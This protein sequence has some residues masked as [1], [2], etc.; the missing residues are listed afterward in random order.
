MGVFACAVWLVLACVPMQ[1]WGWRPGGAGAE[2]ARRP[3]RQVAPSDLR[4]ERP[5]DRRRSAPVES[6]VALPDEPSAAPSPSLAGPLD[7]G[8]LSRAAGRVAQTPP[9]AQGTMDHDV[10]AVTAMPWPPATPPDVTPAS[11][12]W[13]VESANQPPVDWGR[14][15]GIIFL[16]GAGAALVWL[17]LGHATLWW[18]LR[19]ASG[20]PAWVSAMVREALPDGA[21]EPH[22]LLVPQLAR[23]ASLGVWRPV[24][25]LPAAL[26][27]DAP[28][29][30]VRQVV[31]HELGHVMRRD[32]VGNAIFNLALPALW[33]HP[34]YWW[35]RAQASLSRELVA[36]D[37]AAGFDGKAAY[38]AELVSLAR[39]RLGGAGE[40][41]PAL[42]GAGPAGVIGIFGRGSDFFRRM[43][44]LLQNDG[45]L[46]VRCSRVWRVGV[47]T[48]VAVAV[49]AGAGLVGVGPVEAANDDAPP[50]IKETADSELDIDVDLD[51]ELYD[52]Q[53]RVA[54]ALYAEIQALRKQRGDLIAQI[55]AL[56]AQLVESR[57]KTGEGAEERAK[58]LHDR[59][60]E[61]LMR[62]SEL[63][64]RYSTLRSQ[65]AALA[66]AQKSAAAQYKDFKAATDAYGA[67][68]STATPRRETDPSAVAQTT[69]PAAGGRTGFGGG[70]AGGFSRSRGGFGSGFG[71]GE[72]GGGGGVSVGGG[73][74]GGGGMGGGVQL[75]L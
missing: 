30:R 11:I 6:F 71:G 15:A 32:A 54:P 57:R 60:A 45:R 72:S 24:I 73:G 33:F 12:D 2:P 43:R 28:V 31:L 18:M 27:R 39:S 62:R 3:V 13:P 53:K 10:E 40:Q 70:G 23:P 5:P 49:A 21:V 61:A 67:K 37:W 68:A 20:A 58:A 56:D 63:D 4:F 14:M 17:G 46:A 59:R 35:L 36:D 66:A 44:M 42:A 8:E 19:R 7:F 1:R 47:A 9:P 25:L 48:V 64:T 16:C 29:A 51:E 65:A 50:D 74:G 38:V 34:L 69:P 55:R 75:D 52:D 41:E 22:V 26:L